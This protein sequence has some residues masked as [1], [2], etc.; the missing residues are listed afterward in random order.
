MIKYKFLIPV[1]GVCE[2]HYFYPIKPGLNGIDYHYCQHLEI[3]KLL[4]Q[5]GIGFPSIGYFMGTHDNVPRWCPLAS[6]NRGKRARELNS[7]YLNTIKK[8]KRQVLS[9]LM[10]VKE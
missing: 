8:L 1:C 9:L 6:H 7:V 4:P 5:S 3:V 2:H 10:G